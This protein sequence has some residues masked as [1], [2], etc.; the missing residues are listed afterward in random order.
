MSAVSKGTSPARLRR[1]YAADNKVGE[2]ILF[3]SE[4][5]YDF[6]NELFPIWYERHNRPDYIFDYHFHDFIEL[7]V[8]HEGKL[9]ILTENG[10]YYVGPNEIF[11]ANRDEVHA[12]F[13]A[14]AQGVLRYTYY[15]IKLNTI[16]IFPDTNIRN[17]LQRLL[18][19]SV[20]IKSHITAKTH[21]R[22]NLLETLKHVSMR[23]TE[24][25]DHS[26]TLAEVSGALDILHD[27][28]LYGMLLPVKSNVN[29]R[30]KSFSTEVLNYIQSHYTE[31]ITT[32]VICDRFSYNESQFC[33]L[34]KK[35]FEVSF[36]DFLN[37]YRIKMACCYNLEDK[38]LSIDDIA[39]RV[40]YDNYSYFCR[41]FKKYTGK[42]P[43]QYFFG[44]KN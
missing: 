21:G 39:K 17:L 43:K 19:D 28:D 9:R 5:T 8:V 41:N 3:I 10:K 6:D 31:R 38:S 23:M 44:D 35:H 18:S 33:R 36:L 42:S 11:V 25:K 12:G 30:D 34:F 16:A 7:L 15:H 26:N 2:F 1:E 27:L 22:D 24:N 29:F 20:R 37:S 14:E 32:K 40:G 13:F 4:L